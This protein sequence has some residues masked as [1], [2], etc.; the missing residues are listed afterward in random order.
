MNIG[1]GAA[2][3][4]RRRSEAMDH[5]LGT[6]FDAAA[7]GSEG[8]ALVAVGGYGRAEL[9]PRSDLD[10]VLV[11]DPRV[12]DDKVAAVAEA[13]WYPLW[14]DGLDL[15]HAVRDT[16]QM[17]GAAATD[18]RTAIGM[19]DLRHL[20]GDEQLSHALRWTALGDWRRDA[21]RR[22]PELRAAEC[23]RAARFGELADAA[24]PDLKESVGGL[25]D[26]VILRAMVAS[27]LVDVPNAEAEACRAELLDIRDAL[28]EVTGRRTNRLAPELL[29]DLAESLAVTPHGLARHVRALGRRVS[30]LTQLTWRRLDQVLDRP[31][32][33]RPW[34][35]RQPL[36]R[37]HSA[38]TGGVRRSIGVPP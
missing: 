15:D 30:Q 2:E 23:E 19:L 29:P 17:R 16:G 36:D 5:R 31:R 25:R 1:A 6:V 11:H 14:D 10:V 34:T 9:A 20:A 37:A 21:W 22:L 27:W 28:H 24:V 8:F 35:R 7:G 32:R 3:C 13:V 12:S 33:A 38:P 18:V 26:G 4:R